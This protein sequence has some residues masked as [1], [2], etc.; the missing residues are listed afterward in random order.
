MYL[1]QRFQNN[2]IYRLIIVPSFAMEAF[3]QKVIIT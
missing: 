3:L 2:S 1:G